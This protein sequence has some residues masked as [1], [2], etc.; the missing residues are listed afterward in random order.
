MKCKYLFIAL[1]IFVVSHLYINFPLS[2]EE[3]KEG[4]AAFLAEPKFF[5]KTDGYFISTFAVWV[6]IIS[7]KLMG[8]SIFSIRLPNLIAGAFLLWASFRVS[9]YLPIITALSVL[10]IQISVQSFGLTLVLAFAFL[11]LN[12]Y[13]HERFKAL[14]VYLFCMPFVSFYSFL[15]VF[16]LGLKLAFRK[17]YFLILPT[18]WLLIIFKT[19]LSEY[20]FHTSILKYLD[21][22]SY[23]YQIDN[24]LSYGVIHDSVL[25]LDSFNLNR[26]FYNKP[27]FILRRIFSWTTNMFDYETLTSFGKASTIL[28]KQGLPSKTLP[29]VFFWEVPLLVFAGYVFMLSKRLSE[30]QF[31]VIGL[32]SYWFWGIKAFAFVLL[33]IVFSYQ[34][35]IKGITKL[36]K[37]YLYIGIAFVFVAYADYFNSFVYKTDWQ[38]REDRAHFQIW[39]YLSQEDIDNHDVIVTDRLGDAVYYYLFYEKVSTQIYKNKSRMGTVTQ[40]GR[41]RIEQV[42]NVRFMSFDF[43]SAEKKAGQIWIGLPSEFKGYEPDVVLGDFWLKKTS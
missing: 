1:I 24:K 41:R 3:A 16:I 11:S 15:F 31:V 29:F 12:A 27:S 19:Q 8:L 21:P 38:N 5:Y 9:K 18:F 10:F 43:S 35:L 4:Y 32:I 26:F 36:N 37:K 34:E 20:I 33:F 6:K 39:Q 28:E 2:Y 30:K 7:V 22:S 13:Q 25:I 40:D 14:F 17:K 23:V 42:G